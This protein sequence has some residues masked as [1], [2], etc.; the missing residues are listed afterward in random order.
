MK[1]ID[2]NSSAAAVAEQNNDKYSGKFPSGVNGD[3]AVSYGFYAHG[4]RYHVCRKYS[5]GEV[6]PSISN[7]TIDVKYHIA[8]QNPKR[9]C[10]VT[11]VFNKTATIDFSISELV[12]L[13]KF[14]TAVESAGNYIFEGSIGDLAKI[15][16]KLYTEEKSSIEIARLGQNKDKWVW[17]NGI[18]FKGKFY[19]IDETGIV[20]LKEGDTD[21][22]YF[23]PV[24]GNTVIDDETLAS[25]RR[26]RHKFESE[27]T[28]STWAKLMVEVYGDH[29]K[30]GLA[31]ILFAVF[32]DIVHESNPG[33]PILY[34]LGQKSTGKGTFAESLMNLFGEPQDQIMLGSRP[35]IPAMMRKI[36]Q[37]T[38]AVVWYDEFKNNIDPKVNDVIKTIWDRVGRELGVKDHTN[39]TR[40]VP[41]T[42]SA[43][44]SGQE[45]PSNDPATPSRLIL[46]KFAPR[47]YTNEQVERR[48]RLRQIE[49]AGITSALHDVLNH[50]DFVKGKFRRQIDSETK[51]PIPNDFDIIANK[52]RSVFKGEGVHPRMINNY[53]KLV[54]MIKIIEEKITLPFTHEDVLTLS[55]AQIKAQKELEASSAE[56]QMFFEQIQYLASQKL[57]N[58]GIDFWIDSKLNLKIRL[59]NVY[60]LYREYMRRQDTP[61][62]E[63]GTLRSYLK[64][65]DHYD[66]R[67]SAISGHYFPG[68]ACATRAMVFNP[69]KEG[70]IH[71]VNFLEVLNKD[72]YDE[73][74]NPLTQASNDAA[75]EALI[76]G[77]AAKPT[78]DDLP[79]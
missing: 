50:R 19:P 7:F 38:N 5:G 70:R 58:F 62:L 56:V 67:G 3:E 16:N 57:I 27:I 34:L 37:T 60:P 52:L 17:A 75:Q 18:Y 25:Y 21:R 9:I 23:I 11:N 6:W 77:G 10:E 22:Y 13:E 73:M 68:L 69:D 66:G 26:F 30:V 1:R 2:L 14:K 33:A 12:S 24:M 46:A 61:S 76:G 44:V 42:S 47:E 78:N 31:W 64:E 39:K 65:S 20:K 36:S 35:S 48:N 59:D 55:I 41:V 79:F 32:A 4:N 71:G 29:A 53:A 72:Q 28:F 40:S 8:G 43:I 49:D 15:K 63:K 45:F 51:L 74:K 54:V